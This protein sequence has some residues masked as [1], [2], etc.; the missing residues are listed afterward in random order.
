[1]AIADYYPY[2]FLR[3]YQLC[4]ENKI[5]PLIGVKVIIQDDK[6]Q[7]SITIYPQN[8]VGYK[9]L[10]KKIFGGSGSPADRVFPLT[11]IMSLKKNCLLVFLAHNLH[12][13][14]Y[15][16]RQSFLA[17]KTEDPQF[18]IGFD[19]CIAEP[20]KNIPP[21]IL[22][23]LLPFFAVKVISSED[24]VALSS[25]KFTSLAEY[26]FPLDVQQKFIPLLSSAEK[27][28]SVLCTDDKIFSKILFA[29]IR[30]FRG[31]I[32]LKFSFSSSKT[33]SEDKDFP[34]LQNRCERQLFFLQKEPR[35]KYENR[36][37]EELK[38]IKKLGYT[39]YFLIFNDIVNDLRQQNITVGPGRG[40]AVSSLVA[41]LLGITKID[42]L[43]YNL[44][45]ERFL[46]EKRKSLPD[47]DID[48]E[49]QKAVIKHLQNKYGTEKIAR[50]ATRQKLG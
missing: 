30:S 27:E 20:K 46:N 3:F 40:S 23:L 17:E 4:K 24:S 19:F 11:E 29:Q 47:I 43:E 9:E 12:D 2:D 49:N 14:Y 44:F 1:M 34:E 6:K 45:F 50:V 41:Y 16:S 36:L 21:S 13:I 8:S 26:F 7:Y 33:S 5:K 10:I 25:V 32:N 22:P 18:Y 48:V 28:L 38:V 39:R 31:R 42:P 15:F 37:E 35:E